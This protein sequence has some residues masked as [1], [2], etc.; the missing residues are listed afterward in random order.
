[1]NVALSTLPLMS[2]LLVKLILFAPSVTNT[3][4]AFP[5]AVGNV[6]PANV[7]FVVTKL[8]DVTVPSAIVTF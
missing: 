1:M 3:C 2:V 8:L 6:M 4:P 7:K 5:S